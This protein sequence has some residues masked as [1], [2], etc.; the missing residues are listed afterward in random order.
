MAIS[1]SLTQSVVYGVTDLDA[2]SKWY[3]FAI[4]AIPA[5]LS[6]VPAVSGVYGVSGF[7]CWIQDDGSQSRVSVLV[8]RLCLFYIPLWLSTIYNFVNYIRIWRFVKEYFSKEEENDDIATKKQLSI[9]KKLT[10]YPLIMVVCY[11][12]ATIN[13]IY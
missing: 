10:L 12:F 2:Y 3:Y 1:W 8:W 9:I 11:L 7:Y 5:L 4:F 6:I 13:K